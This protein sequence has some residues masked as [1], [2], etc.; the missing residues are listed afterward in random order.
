M[1]PFKNRDC[2]LVLE[3]S[4]DSPEEFE[5]VVALQAEMEAGLTSGE[6]DGNDVGLGVVNTPSRWNYFFVG[7][8]AVAGAVLSCFP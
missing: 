4:G 5:R 3:F 6:V 7:A 1:W 8:S 2:Q